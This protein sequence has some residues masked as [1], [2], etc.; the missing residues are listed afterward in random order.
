MDMML[1]A[2]LIGIGIAA[3]VAQVVIVAATLLNPGLPFLWRV[4]AAALAPMSLLFGAVGWLFTQPS[5][6]LGAPFAIV[7]AIGVGVIESWGILSM[8]RPK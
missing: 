7:L 8:K 1:A 5:G 4:A 3:F 6:Y 2:V